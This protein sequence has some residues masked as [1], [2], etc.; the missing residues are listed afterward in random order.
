MEW[1]KHVRFPGAICLMIHFDP[2]SD[3]SDEHILTLN[4]GSNKKD[5]IA[6]YVGGHWPKEPL[7][8]RSDETYFHF[9]SRERDY[10]ATMHWGFRATVL[11]IYFHTYKYQWSLELERIISWLTGVVDNFY[12]FLIQRSSWK[13]SAKMKKVSI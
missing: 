10:S 5:T 11:P 4:R 3:V 13:K 9:N 6:Q 8:L 2:N 12:F 7:F 1:E